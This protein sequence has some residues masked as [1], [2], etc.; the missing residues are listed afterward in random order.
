MWANHDWYDIQ[1]YNPADPCKLL[2]PGAVN[3][4]TWEKITDRMVETY[5]AHPSYWK[6]EEKPYFSIYDISVFLESFG[7][8]E[9]ARL[10][11]DR[12]R[13]KVGAA[14]HPGLHLNAI[15]WG[16]PNLPGSRTPTDWPRLCRDLALDSLTG[17]TWVHHGALNEDTFPISDYN[18]G[19][20]RYLAF[21]DHALT[22]YPVP[23]FPNTTVHWDNSPRAHADACWNKPAAHVVNPVMTGNTPAAFKEA[24][25]LIANRLLATAK[26][27][28]HILTVNAWNEWPEGSCLEPSEKFGLGYL[29]AL[30]DL[31]GPT[32]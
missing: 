15:L 18:W 11:L 16:E 28:P 4:A 26:P 20:D 21:L 6:I 29:E 31:F 25:R 12:F 2:Y 17:Y 23:Y 13:E 1:G 8:V 22:Y 5:F 3:K 19:R 7:S 32:A 30:Q 10:A 14:G 24:T 9:K 27:Q